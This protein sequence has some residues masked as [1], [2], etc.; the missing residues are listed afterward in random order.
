MADYL[1]NWEQAQ[2]ARLRHLQFQLTDDQLA[3]IEQALAR[4]LPKAKKK[5]YNPNA[6]GN[7]LYLSMQIL[8]GEERR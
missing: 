8:S 3:V 4:L 1:Q 7:A 2:E 6:R 5:G